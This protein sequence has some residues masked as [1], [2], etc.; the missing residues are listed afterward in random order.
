[1]TFEHDYFR[2]KRIRLVRPPSGNIFHMSFGSY[3][4]IL[5]EK[6]STYLVYFTGAYG[7]GD[8]EDGEDI[9]KML[10]AA[11]GGTRS[12]QGYFCSK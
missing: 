6:N 12:L 8:N 2:I 9:L 4:I 10:L 3:Q 7:T 11:G 1:M 5:T